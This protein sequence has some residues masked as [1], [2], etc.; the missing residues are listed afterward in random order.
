MGG[1][2]TRSWR[3]L[4]SSGG[5]DF[6]FPGGPATGKWGDCYCRLVPEGEVWG[7]ALQGQPGSLS[8]MSLPGRLQPLQACPCRGPSRLGSPDT[9][10]SG[11][12]PE[13]SPR[14]QCYPIG[15]PKGRRLSIPHPKAQLRAVAVVTGEGR[16][17]PGRM[18]GER[19]PHLPGGQVATS[20]G[21]RGGALFGEG[22]WEAE[23]QWCPQP[24]PGAA[25]G[26][27]GEGPA[28]PHLAERMMTRASSSRASISR[29]VTFLVPGSNCSTF[30]ACGVS[31]SVSRW[32][33]RGH[34]ASGA[35]VGPQP[36]GVRGSSARAARPAPATCPVHS[37][38]CRLAWPD[39][40]RP[41]CACSLACAA[42]ALGPLSPPVTWSAVR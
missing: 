12:L 14:V 5:L 40:A 6:P 13:S 27:V 36:L 38:S 25:R 9:P 20:P 26:A 8:L 1:P 17:K 23:V 35:R 4:C 19:A 11:P 2:S 33:G 39:L 3:P 30:S 22:T 15:L 37:P 29:A 34:S 7:R 18:D 21:P 28:Q 42:P 32:P 41:S 24:R 10:S 16:E 31:R